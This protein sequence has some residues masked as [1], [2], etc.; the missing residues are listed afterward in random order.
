M[1]I[2]ESIIKILLPTKHRILDFNG[3]VFFGFPRCSKKPLGWLDTLQI[4]RS[5]VQPVPLEQKKMLFFWGV[6]KGAELLW[7]CVDF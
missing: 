4:D 1:M 6:L 7:A 5:I 2:I 3:R